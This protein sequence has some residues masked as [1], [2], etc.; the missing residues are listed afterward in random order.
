MST[1]K[2]TGRQP[3]DRS[4]ALAVIERMSLADANVETRTVQPEGGK[5]NSVSVNITQHAA[6][7]HDITEGDVVACMPAGPGY[8]VCP[9]EVLETSDE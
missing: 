7:L 9:M 1:G 2:R 4:Q 3:S 8:F 5:G 6:K